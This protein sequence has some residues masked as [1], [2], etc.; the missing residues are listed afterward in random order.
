MYESLCAMI[1][2][3]FIRQYDL[4]DD[5]PLPKESDL[6]HISLAKTFNVILSSI[7]EEKR[8]ELIKC[9]DEC[10]KGLPNHLS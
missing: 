2:K 6:Y 10:R 3:E 9:I 4:P 8:Q 1:L 5:L 7:H